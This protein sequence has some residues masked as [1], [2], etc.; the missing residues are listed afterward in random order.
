MRS[1]DAIL[2][3][4][5]GT[6]DGRD[7][8]RDRFHRLFVDAGLAATQADRVRAFDYAEE[9]SRATPE[10]ANASLRDMLRHHVAWQLSSMGIDDPGIMR[11]V[12]D[13]FA[14]EV[15]EAA[16]SN[17]RVLENLVEQGFRVGIVSN[18]CG[19]SA[20]LCEEY[21]YAPF[22]SALVDSHRFGHAKP[23]PA[24]FRH[25][26]SLLRTRPKRTGFV[27]DSLDRDIAPAKA[28]GMRTFWIAGQRAQDSG[29]IADVVLT[30]VADLPAH[31][32]GVAA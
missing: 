28:L 29:G 10:M 2:F 24:I 14:A 23:D 27:G 1:L 15:A 4:L 11:Q 21:G 6:L 31:L 8:W 19:N 30:S 26:L 12:I 22:L 18:A 3:D 32:G 17:R 25:A 16:A 13:Q 5:G 20:V 7:A 9:R